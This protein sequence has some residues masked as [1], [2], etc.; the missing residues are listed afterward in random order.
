MILFLFSTPP[1]FVYLQQF[2][3]CLFY[4][5][6]FF[7]FIISVHPLKRHALLCTPHFH[8]LSAPSRH[9]NQFDP[10]PTPISFPVP[11][12]RVQFFWRHRVHFSLRFP[13][14]HKRGCRCYKTFRS[15]TEVCKQLCEKNTIPN[16]RVLM[17]TVSFNRAK[18]LHS[19]LSSLR[20]SPLLLSVPNKN[21]MFR[22]S[23]SECNA[24]HLKHKMCFLC[25]F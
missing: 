22:T 24:R 2:S 15:Q 13:N 17:K 20:S 6:H 19:I 7:P 18:F 4:W 11:F 16:R 8:C 5:L 9:Q 12:H 1:P 3:P 21:S 10:P 14:R 23:S 25:P